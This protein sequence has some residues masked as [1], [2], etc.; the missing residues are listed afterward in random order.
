ML[1]TIQHLYQTAIRTTLLAHD[2]VTKQYYHLFSVIELLPAE[3]PSYNIPNATWFQDKMILSTYSSQLS[4]YT[5]SLVILPFDSVT[6]GI[7]AFNEP[8][9][10]LI[11][12]EKIYFFNDNF[13]KEPSGE[14]P[15]ILDNNSYQKDGLLAV[16]PKH[17]S[18]SMLWSQIDHKRTTEI[19][20][21]AANLTTN[22]KA[23]SQ[24]T[25]DWLG[26]DIWTMPEHIG[27]IYLN[28][29]N[30]YYRKLDLTLSNKPDGVL[31]QFFMREDISERLAIRIIDKHGDYLALDKRFELNR[32]YRTTS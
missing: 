21:K 2:N 12:G 6:H 11:D 17:K 26:F 10:Q 28:A 13:S 3:I 18:G 9:T 31:Y 29:V 4:D 16:I 30:P 7:Q 15:L 20:F 25:F 1:T 5:F 23:M 32:I 8:L 24:L 19:K 14:Y 22:M 27:N